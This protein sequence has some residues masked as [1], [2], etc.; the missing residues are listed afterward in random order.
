MLTESRSLDEEDDQ[1]S[2]EFNV[3]VGLVRLPGLPQRSGNDFNGI[4]TDSSNRALP[5]RGGQEP[6]EAM[7]K[8]TM[9]IQTLTDPESPTILS[10]EAVVVGSDASCD[11]TVEGRGVSKQHAEVYRV[12]DLWWVRD[13]GTDDGTYLDGDLIEAAPVPREAVLELGTGGIALLLEPA[14][15]DR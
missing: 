3:P 6:E 5:I 7:K 2:Q 11:Y 12:G 8:S 15:L 1:V 10:A 14:V 9:A 13:L 4:K